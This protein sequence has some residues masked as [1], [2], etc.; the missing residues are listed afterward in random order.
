M[1]ESNFKAHIPSGRNFS[2][3]SLAA[4]NSRRLGAFFDLLLQI[5]KRNHPELYERN[6]SEASPHQAPKRSDGICLCGD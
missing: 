4:D 1:E 6:Q 3:E 5:D 2:A